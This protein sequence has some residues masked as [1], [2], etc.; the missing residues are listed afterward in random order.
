MRNVA[1]LLLLCLLA[2]CSLND[3]K[4]D[5]DVLNETLHTIFNRKSVRQYTEKPVEKEK[6]EILLKAGMTA[7]SSMDN[8]PWS[9]VVVT[10]RAMLDTMAEGLPYAKMLKETKQAIVVCGDTTLSPRNWFIDC[11]AVTQN[12]LLAAESMELGAVWTAVYPND[13]RISIVRNTLNIPGHVIP[14]AVVPFGYPRGAH[15]PK[16]KY[17]PARIHVNGW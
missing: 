11:S 17:D 8:R 7:P 12:I 15:S 16:D 10:D 9:F 4:P 2:G 1:F 3:P 14:L 5:P 13:N 6:I